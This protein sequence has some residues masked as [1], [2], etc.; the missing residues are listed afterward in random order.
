MPEI[1]RVNT[2]ISEAAAA[3]ELGAALRAAGEV[4]NGDQARL[5]LAQ[6]WLETA[7]GQSCQNHNVGNIT[8]RDNSSADFY[9][10]PWFAVDESSSPHLHALHEAM[11]KGEAPRAFRSFDDFRRGFAAYVWELQHQFPTL[12]AAARTGDPQAVGNAIRSSHYAPDAPAGTGSSLAA[13]A[14]EF[15]ARGRFTDLPKAPAPAAP[16]PPACSS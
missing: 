12:L 5:L 8:T 11:L 16:V 14:K 2:P 7:R 3:D 1:P 9:R 6:I 15:E 10:P 13:L 4:P